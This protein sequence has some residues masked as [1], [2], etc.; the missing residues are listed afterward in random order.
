MSTTGTYKQN[1]TE[2]G[3]HDNFAFDAKAENGAKRNSTTSASASGSGSGS[4]SPNIPS[5]MIDKGKTKLME[6][7]KKEKHHTVPYFKLYR[8]ATKFEIFLLVVG[9]ICKF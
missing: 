9:L 1:I 4:V 8:F 5:E 6:K 7:K 2:F 3:G